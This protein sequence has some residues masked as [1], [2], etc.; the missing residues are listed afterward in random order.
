[1]LQILV[2]DGNARDG[3]ARHLAATG[4]TS[5][6]AYGDILR[7]LAPDVGVTILNP[8]DA[9]AELPR[10]TG[11]AGFDG[12]IVTGSVLHVTDATPAVQRQVALMRDCLAA[13][14]PVFGSCWGVQVAAVVAGGRAGR[15]PRGPE[16][17]FAR[18]IV[19]TR[20]GQAHPLLAGRPAAFDA[21]AMH[22]DAVI[23]P[24]P[25]CRVL[26]ENGLLAVQA[27]EIVRGAGVF[28]GTQYHPELDLDALA[29][30]LR[31]SSAAVLEA[32]L[33]RTREAV[34]AYA[35]DLDALHADP[36]GR[37][38]LVW[39]HGLGPAVIEPRQRRREIANFLEYLVRPRARR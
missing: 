32:G 18:R 20:T 15:N 12:I 1:M 26:A 35:A 37:I 17:G 7:A 5:A 24:P 13:A 31:L 36:D 34:E 33:C 11:L 14:R 8:A 23:E 30:M 27:I 6:E 4:R 29:A 28:W 3:R 25:G 2:A 21:P 22:L 9:D 10:G 16:Y 19:P 38:D 39:R